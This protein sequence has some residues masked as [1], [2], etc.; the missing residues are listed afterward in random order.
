MRYPSALTKLIESFQ[1]YPGIGPKTA[2]RLAFFT[3]QKLSSEKVTAFSDALKEAL[4]KIKKCEICGNITDTN[5][6]DVCASG[7]RD[8]DLMIVESA[9]DVIVFEKTNRYN[10]KY[11]VL[12]GLISPLNGI[13][14]EDINLKT[15]VSRVEKEKVKEIIIATSASIEG[16]MTAL[17]IKNILEGKDV[18]VTRI[19]YGLPVGGDIEYADEI[20]LIRSL[21]GRKKL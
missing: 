7:I 19:G 4:Q 3:I 12:G 16:E 8:N 21:E 18:A 20:T 13:S 11:H 9:K 17:Y 10:G 5:I 2:E 6:C 1:M 15:L 14:P